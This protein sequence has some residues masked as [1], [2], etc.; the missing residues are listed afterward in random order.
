MVVKI[1]F[2]LKVKHNIVYRG[3]FPGMFGKMGDLTSQYY[4]DKSSS[5]ISPQLPAGCVKFR[6]KWVKSIP[7]SFPDTSTQCILK[8]RKEH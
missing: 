7:I 8:G 3:L 5:E 6:E 1:C 4:L 2:Y